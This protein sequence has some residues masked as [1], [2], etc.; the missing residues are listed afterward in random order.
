MKTTKVY[1]K[2]VCPICLGMFTPN[3]KKHK[4]CNSCRKNR[5]WAIRQYQN[6][7]MTPNPKANVALHSMCAEIEAYNKKHGTNLTY[8][9]YI[10][11]KNAGWLED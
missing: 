11:Y 9:K 8:G 10:Q 7:I 6:G 4:F 2:R 5:R 3:T 1:P